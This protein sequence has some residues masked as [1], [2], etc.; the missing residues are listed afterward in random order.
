M[1]WETIRKRPDDYSSANLA[2]YDS[3]AKAFSWSQARALLDGLPDGGLNIAHE[4]VDRHVAAGRGDKLALR[5]IGRDDLIRDFTYAGL[6]AQTN[7][8]AN[9]LAACGVAKGDR[10]FALLG[11]SP[12]LYIAALG[13][14]KNGSVFSPLFSAFGPEPI[15]ARMTIGDAKAL[16]TSEAFYRRKI[17]PWRKELAS[18]RH[19]F[20]TECSDSLPPD[21]IDL[22]AAMATAS[23]SFATVWTAP[24]D[25]AL[26]H[27][28]S[29]TTGRPKGAVHVHEAVVA[30]H[31]TGRI[32]L[33]LHPNDVF[34]CTADPGWVTG[35]SY[36]IISP[37]TNGATMIVDQAEFDAERWYRILQEQKITIW[38]TAPTA[39][40]MLMKIG[41][42]ITKRYDLSN[43]RFMASVGEPLN[44]EAVVW[45]VEA[46]G[47]PF[48]DNWWQTETGGIMIANYPSMDVKPGSMGR[49]LPGVKAAI[50]ERTEGG[51]VRE[52]AKPMAMGE[53]ALRPG[54]P[55]MMRAYLNEEE[56]Y[57]KCFVGGW[58]LTGD[59]AMR[60]ADGY[61]W[62]VG[63]ADDVIKS[64]GHLIGPFEVE[65]A[66]MEHAAVAEAGV[67]GIP[68]ATAGEVVKAFVAL[69]HG[70]EPGEPLR[71]DL[72][73][74]ARK[75]LGPA[76]APKDIAFRQ[77][78]PKTRSGKIMRRLLK[79]RELGLPEGDISTLESEE[80]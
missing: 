56:R 24:E 8:F 38:Y 59:L 45:G 5:W 74:H 76:I 19:V 27:F 53:L 44:P 9:T 73:G 10:V 2:D 41:A 21:T 58:Y 70:F 61:Y 13:T 80:R 14:L 48:H 28:T 22:G 67:I 63:R 4:A 42:D 50:V 55:S 46:F 52:A 77:N 31:V 68:D 20:L 51:Q 43:L 3:Y 12:E 30:H 33:D 71:K 66:L 35:T 32:A 11:R 65:S 34:W 40:R 75:R 60:D 79:A 54:W 39:I 26:L 36:G 62:F 37:L 18:L 25:M 57:R 69:K 29:G 47:K 7:R 23:D 16:V 64:A 6:R 17:E 72:L 15:K 49:P 1:E 78:L